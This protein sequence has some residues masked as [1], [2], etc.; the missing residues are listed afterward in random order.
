MRTVGD[1]SFDPDFTF[2]SA[3]SLRCGGAP[4]LAVRCRT[5]E[6]LATAVGLVDA[7]GKKCV[8]VGGGS[9]MVVADGELD[10]VAVIAA[11][12]GLHVDCASGTVIAGAGAT[13]DDVVATA[14]GKGLGG[15]EALSGIPGSAGATPVQNVGAYGA[16]IAD[17]LVSVELYD[18]ENRTLSWVP[19]ADLDL[20]YRYSNLK[21]TARG[22]V[23]A[24]E[25]K[26]STDGLSAPLRYGELARR[27]GAEKDPASTGA[28]TLRFPVAEVRQAVLDLRRG[29]GMVLDSGD[30]DTWSAGSFFTNPIVDEHVA[31]LAADKVAALHGEKES[32][33]MPRFAAPGGKVKLSAAWLIERAGYPK[34]YPGKGPATLSTKHTLALTNR[35]RATTADIA[36]LAREIRDGVKAR[37]GVELVPEPVWIGTGINDAQAS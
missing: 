14:V 6:A 31:D 11:D 3:T 21:H 35:G 9:N 36:A 10:V 33:T 2:A 16:E 24:I 27:L 4:R 5:A 26:L 8:V 7:A 12:T 30:H 28:K 15:I 22:V 17:V 34:G 20:A 1:L 37:L 23:C 19:A 29:K 32:S 13:W 18:R 25:L